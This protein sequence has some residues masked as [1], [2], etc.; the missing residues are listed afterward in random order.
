MN[1]VRQAA[2]AKHDCGHGLAPT[3]FRRLYSI[4]L[5]TCV[6]RA[7]AEE[8]RAARSWSD[9]HFDEFNRWENFSSLLIVG[10]VQVGRFASLIWKWSFVLG[11]EMMLSLIARDGANACRF[12][13]R[14][15]LRHT[16]EA[17]RPELQ[18]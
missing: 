9:R 5:T 16:H 10:I 18:Q 8:S 3:H 6:T 14:P 12:E 7:R 2:G 17:C 4:F 1:T 13:G 11:R 15:G